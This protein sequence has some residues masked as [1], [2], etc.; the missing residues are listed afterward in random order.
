MFDPKKE[1]AG[2]PFILKPS[3]G[4]AKSGVRL[5]RG[6]ADLEAY[7]SEMP[8]DIHCIREEFI[9][10]DEIIAAGIAEKGRFYLAEMTDKIMTAHPFFVDVRH[11]APSKYADR[12]DEIEQIG[13]SVVDA[14]EIN[15]SPVFLEIRFDGR[16]YP[17]VIEVVP[18][19]GGEFLADLL[20]PEHTGYPFIRSCVQALSLSG[21][22]PPLKKRSRSAVIVQYITA[23]S[24]GILTSHN[25][26]PS[27]RTDGLVFCK[28]FKEIGSAVRKA[29]TN[30][31]RLGVVV[32]KGKTVAD[33]IAA[34]EAV[35][36]QLSIIIK[37][38]KK[39][40]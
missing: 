4:H 13:Q 29:E 23:Q 30:H 14:F 32:T 18:D 38:A 25:P 35:I 36:D 9:G 17:F 15:T 39:Q 6:S 20:I 34:A 21:F 12:W 10:G 2:F 37:P 8:K 16:G 28:I 5:I 22:V 24:D 27:S 26:V 33:A 11:Q 40:K 19:F 31:D 1:A 3:K 7:L